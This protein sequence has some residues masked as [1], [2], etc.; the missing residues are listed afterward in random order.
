M[1][2]TTRRR[3]ASWLLPVQTRGQVQCVADLALR[4][5]PLPKKQSLAVSEEVDE[6]MR[7]T[8]PRHCKACTAGYAMVQSLLL[9]TW[10]ASD[11]LGS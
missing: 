2:T 11:E 6:E 1:L 10:D 5:H 7:S 3:R 9:V 8:P 4:D